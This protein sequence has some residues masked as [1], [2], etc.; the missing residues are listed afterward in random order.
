MIRA[1]LLLLNFTGG[2]R[3]VVRLLADR[4]I[5]LGLKMLF[6]AA[7]AYIVLPF[8]L[9]PDFL[10]AL[11]RIDDLLALVLATVVFLALSPR[12]IITEHLGRSSSG[13][14]GGPRD[15]GRVIDGDYRIIDDEN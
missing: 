5:P 13:E 11:G 8:D 10:L 3:L 7:L 1:F 12:H 6:P 9:I 15:R 2:L 14:G 4:R